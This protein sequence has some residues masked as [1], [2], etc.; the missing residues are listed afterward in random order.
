MADIQERTDGKGR[1]RFTARVRVHGHK[2]QVATFDTKTAASRWAIKTESA[3]REGK[4]LP[5]QES[6]RRTL[7]EL[8][9]QYVETVLPEKSPST[10]YG[11]G[12]Q[13]AHWR[14]RLGHMTLSTV[15]APVIVAER[16]NLAK[17]TTTRKEAGKLDR[18]T[19]AK[20]KNASKD[21]PCKRRTPATVNRYLAA[22]SSCLTHGQ[23]ELRWIEQNP[24]RDVKKKAEPRGRVRILSD[25]ERKALLAA[26]LNS[27]NPDLH[28]IVMLLL[29]TAAR[30]NEIGH[31]Q[32]KHV[33]FE[34]RVIVLDETKNGERRVIPLRGEAE[35]ILLERSRIRRIDSPYVF[36][37]PFRR[38]KA[39]KPMDIQT[40]WDKAVEETKLTDFRMHD[41][42]HT[43]ASHLAMS[44]AT[45]A[46]LSE[47]LGHKTLQMVK[48]YSHLTEG[49]TGDLLERMGNHMFKA[50]VEADETKER[51]K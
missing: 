26:C 38:G 36:P 47:V 37:A 25:E 51:V 22:L 31:L 44:G 6:K 10:Q 46:E 23:K 11:Q 42:R 21:E 50:K 27:S 24:M 48:R 15:T 20:G 28:D 35:R 34:R 2:P 3:I 16:E 41:L 1:T 45:L 19:K 43:A 29:T 18:A 39:P 9:D 17:G 4:H 13:L 7:A 14:A 40:A 30:R 5:D 49:H 8:I 32:W 12:I 33:D